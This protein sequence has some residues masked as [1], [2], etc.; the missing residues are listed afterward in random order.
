MQKQD[1][2]GGVSGVGLQSNHSQSKHDYFFTI[3]GYIIY[4]LYCF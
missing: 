3:L 4:I 2:S 1:T